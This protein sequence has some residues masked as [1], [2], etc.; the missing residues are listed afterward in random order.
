MLVVGGGVVGINAAK[1]AIGLG[2][3]VTVFDRSLPRLR[4]LS[5]VFGNNGI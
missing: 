5:D 3:R 1:M 4:Y 2:A